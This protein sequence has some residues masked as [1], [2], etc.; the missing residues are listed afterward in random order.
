MATISH[1]SSSSL[2]SRSFWLSWP[3]E[4]ENMSDERVS[5]NPVK[6]P[7]TVKVVATPRGLFFKKITKRLIL[8]FFWM[9]YL[10][11]PN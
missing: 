5:L 9:E 11:Q 8:S 1:R 3:N 2:F 6:S 7:T 10:E 4:Q